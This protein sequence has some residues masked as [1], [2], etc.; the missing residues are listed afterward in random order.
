MAGKHVTLEEKINKYKERK[1][2]A[3]RE[4]INN[5]EANLYY[6][7]MLDNAYYAGFDAGR[8]IGKLTTEA[9]ENY[10]PSEEKLEKILAEENNGN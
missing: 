8:E 10:G 7:K 3:Y 6:G 4:G 5:L 2:N 1:A 9:L